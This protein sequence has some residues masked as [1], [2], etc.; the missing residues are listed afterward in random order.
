[1]SKPQI[2]ASQLI[3]T[4]G[5]GAMVDLPDEAVIIA[6]IDQWRYN[7]SLP[8]PMISEPRLQQKL[9]KLLG[10]AEVTLRKP[11]PATEDK[12]FT[13]DI[14]AFRFPEWF[15]VQK[16]SITKKGHRARRLVK[17]GDLDGGK[18]RDDD[19]KRYPVVP[20]RFVRAC[21]RG[22]V[23]D[24]E[25]QVFVHGTDGTCRREL[26][27]EDRGISGDMDSIWVRCSCGQERA[28]SQAAR[29]DLVALG[30]CNGSR[31]W[32]GAGTRESCGQPNRLLIRSA[33]NA[34]F[35]QLLS[36]ISIPDSLE[37][38]DRAVTALWESHLATVQ[39]NQQLQFV[40]TMPVVKNQM[41]DFTI[42][43]VMNSIQRKRSGGAGD[44]RP[45]KEAEF[46]ALSEAKSEIGADV[47]EG[48][49][50]ARTLPEKTWTSKWTATLERVVLVH[51]L[52]EVVAQVGFTR[53]EAAGPD[54]QGELDMEVQRAPIGLD[55][56]WLPAIE[57]RGEGIFLQFQP[58]VIDAWLGKKAVKDRDAQLQI[59]FSLWA[60]EHPQ[61]KRVYPGLP[62]FMLH[63]L[64]HL[65][66][67]AISLEC[68]Y[69][70]SSLRER[71]YAA[72]GR[73]GVLIF[74]GSSDAEGT[75]GGLVEE[76]RR[77]KSHLRRALEMGS[78]CS[79]DPVCAFHAP[80]QHDHQPLLG[81]ACHGCLLIS[82][83]SC[84]QHNDFLDRALVVPTVEG[85]GAE[86]FGGWR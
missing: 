51:R 39:D 23:G 42:D 19:G 48:D 74:T 5:P 58:R 9:Q 43:Q 21:P 3:T 64:S 31:P 46:D 29:M 82:E 11:P 34:Y 47:P 26:F 81:S 44:E 57:N 30:K 72:P 24:I 84:E 65:M 55:V 86:F 37:A 50:H 68:G 53:F 10:G 41:G 1:M 76:G 79:N 14:A 52:R 6:A 62:Y 75:L 35:P 22:H 78:L 18:F 36:V 73:Y 85:L 12:G 4:F 70:A 67:T 8:I 83:T 15:I 59:G 56:S 80:T 71:V 33:S 61:S 17:L 13:P 54:I 60:K 77:I 38:V 7:Q 66:L 63:S 45:V 28:M 32:L 49:F 25:W 2:R 69:P 40:M 27:V 16:P 20:I